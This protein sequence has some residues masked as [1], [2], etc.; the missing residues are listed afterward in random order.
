LSVAGQNRWI[1][2]WWL[3]DHLDVFTVR[4]GE[5]ADAGRCAAIVRGLPD[6]FTD[7]VPAK[8]VAD[9]SVHSALVAT[10]GSGVVVGFA[11]VDHRSA[12]AAEILWLAVDASLRGGGVGT[13]LLDRVVR[14]LVESGRQV[15]EVKTLDASAGYEPYQATRAFWERRGFVQ[16][17]TIDPFPGWQPGSPAAIYVA[18]L[19]ATR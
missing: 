5:T 15:V 7:D 12:R 17:D 3:R 6:Y 19:T 11:I 16:I 2:P 1:G 4:P 10:N 9:L 8:I 14:D 18:A 13:L